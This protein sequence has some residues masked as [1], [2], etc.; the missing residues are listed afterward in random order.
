LDGL[1]FGLAATLL[2][3][4][5]KEQ[6]MYTSLS[7]EGRAK[8]KLERLNASVDFLATL[9]G[10]FGIPGTSQ[11]RLSQA[12]KGKTLDNATGIAINRVLDECIALAEAASPLSL[13][14][15]N[16]QHVKTLLDARRDETL[17]IR[18]V[19]DGRDEATRRVDEI[20]EA[21]YADLLNG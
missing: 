5:F 21:D 17:S 2:I 1:K 14:F 15:D 3:F 18:V 16:P 12:F 4:Q 11:T 9:C 7:A 20:D 13:R 19:L 6:K 8:S 10:L